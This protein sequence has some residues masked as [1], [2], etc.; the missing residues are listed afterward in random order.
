MQDKACM[1]INSIILSIHVSNQD[2]DLKSHPDLLIGELPVGYHTYIP[3]IVNEEKS[4]IILHDAYYTHYSLYVK[5]ALISKTEH[6]NVSFNLLL[7]FDQK[8]DEGH[9]VIDVLDKVVKLWKEAV[10]IRINQKYSLTTKSFE[11]YISSITL[12]KREFTFPVMKGST[13]AAHCICN[14]S[15]LGALLNFTRYPL[16]STVAWLELG[17]E[18]PT[19]INLPILQ[20]KE[21]SADNAN[22]CSDTYKKENKQQ[23]TKES[24]KVKTE[25]YQAPVDEEY[26]IWENLKLRSIEILSATTH[27]KSIGGLNTEDIKYD[28]V[29]VTLQEL[30]N[31]E[32]NK[33]AFGHS[34]VELDLKTRRITLDVPPV[35]IYYKLEV[36]FTGSEDGIERIKQN[37]KNGSCKLFISEFDFSNQVENPDAKIAPSQANGKTKFSG[38]VEGYVVCSK[39]DKNIFDKKV[40]VTISITPKTIVP[41][42]TLSIPQNLDNDNKYNYSPKQINPSFF[43]V[44][45]RYKRG[46]FFA[47]TLISH[48]ILFFTLFICIAHW[49]DYNDEYYRLNS[50]E[51]PSSDP[52]QMIP[53]LTAF[54][55]VIL[56]YIIQLLAWTKRLHDLGRT[57]WW[58]LLLYSSFHIIGFLSLL[59][60]VLFYKEFESVNIVFLVLILITLIIHYIGYAYVLFF[61]G[62]QHDNQYGPNPYR[63]K[64]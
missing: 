19:T 27:I 9:R 16:L 21:Q 26:E 58:T 2:G 43:S 3:T 62:Q 25:T 1:K 60:G 50:E 12:N 59:M 22:V 42:S 5:N 28:P 38:A 35:K 40:V 11:E 29:S 34:T 46:R 20:K 57:G 61:K 47:E 24:E 32:N 39:I 23:E 37:L 14:K 13:P 51:P 4:W 64:N 44:I 10:S 41:L 31:A 17:H 6:S 45:G 30:I 56:F 15:Q 55:T 53:I 48:I 63:I 52:N 8:M 33:L 18:C 54:I 7:P 36:K 49:W